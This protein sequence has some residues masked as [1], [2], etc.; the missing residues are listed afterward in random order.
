M[1]KLR[2]HLQSM[3]ADYAAARYDGDLAADVLARQHQR[4]WSRWIVAAGSVAAAA[5][6]MI[7]LT[8]RSQKP[9]D[10]SHVTPTPESTDEN[11]IQIA[12]AFSM[13]ELT[14][15][16]ASASFSPDASASF[17]PGAAPDFSFSVPSITF[18]GDESS[19]ISPTTR[20]S[21]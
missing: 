10:I 7:V 21:V 19:D 17:S 18:V 16:D 8:V 15:E 2:Q 1:S 5:I 6:V 14:T 4:H 3:R 20:E 12:P 13:T 11:Y 9:I